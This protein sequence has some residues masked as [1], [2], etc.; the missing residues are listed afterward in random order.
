MTG[1]APLG[2]LGRTTRRQAPART[3]PTVST[4]GVALPR[5]TAAPA[6]SASR[7]AAVAGLQARRPVALVG[8]LV[9]LVDDDQAELGERRQDGQAGADDDVDRAGPDPPPL[10]GPFAVTQPG[11][12][13]GDPGIEVRSQAVDDRQGQG[14]LGHEQEDR[15]AELQGWPRSPRRRPR[16]CRRR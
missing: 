2:R 11:V 1:G 12:E 5:T 9:L 6:S 3:R 14:D 16:S 13:Q 10:V 4:A 7:I 15:P 8:P